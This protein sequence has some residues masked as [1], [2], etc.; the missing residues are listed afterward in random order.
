M[1]QTPMYQLYSIAPRLQDW[2]RFLSK[3]GNAM[4]VDFDFSKEIARIT[5][6]TLIVAGDADKIS[7]RACGRDVRP[8]RR[9][10]EGSWLG[11]FRS[12]EVAPRHSAR[13][14]PLQH[15]CRP[16][17]FSRRDPVSRFVS[18]GIRQSQIS[19][20][21]GGRRARRRCRRDSARASCVA[22]ETS[23]KRRLAVPTTGA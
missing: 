7:A 14:D 2:P 17:R 22:D 9:R 5:A 11:R 12:S 21:R 15:F 4:K 10:E 8:A 1:K 23:D 20:L 3:M 16:C 6:P 19:H 18:Q 13:T